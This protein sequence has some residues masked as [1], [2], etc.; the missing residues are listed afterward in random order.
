MYMSEVYVYL[1][2]GHKHHKIGKLFNIT[3]MSILMG[4]PVLFTISFKFYLEIPI[5][6]GEHED[7]FD[8]NR[9]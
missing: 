1:R 2:T 9:L 7:R 8:L 4:H 6:H 5:S 3:F